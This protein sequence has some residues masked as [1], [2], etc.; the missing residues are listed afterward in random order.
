MFGL[1]TAVFRLVVMLAVLLAIALGSADSFGAGP[2]GLNCC[3]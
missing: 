2:N 3:P 1:S